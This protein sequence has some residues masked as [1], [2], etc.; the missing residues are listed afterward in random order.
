MG[1]FGTQTLGQVSKRHRRHHLQ[2]AAHPKRTPGNWLTTQSLP[3]PKFYNTE[4]LSLNLLKRKQQIGEVTQEEVNIYKQIDPCIA[5]HFN[6]TFKAS[7]NIPFIGLGVG[8]SLF[9]Y[10]SYFN[11]S[12]P[13][14]V[15]LS[16]FPILIDWARTT[17]DA[18]NEQHSLDFLN[19]V[20][21]YRKAK[22][23]AE[24]HHAEFQNE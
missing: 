17:R 16:V 5:T 20:V 2:T 14:R 3:Y 21:D 8:G 19:W 15:V 6:R 4:L 1:H 22:C 9:L 13:S 11:F 18:V 10:S 24:L 23:F 7:F 12:I